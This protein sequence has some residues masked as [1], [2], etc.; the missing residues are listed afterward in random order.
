MNWQSRKGIILIQ[1]TKALCSVIPLDKGIQIKSTKLKDFKIYGKR[2][3][4]NSK[5]VGGIEMVYNRNL[6]PLVYEPIR[7]R[8]FE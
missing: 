4:K 6:G 5:R 7:I 2:R 8:A 3:S 1:I